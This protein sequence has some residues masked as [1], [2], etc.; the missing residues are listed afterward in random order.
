MVK[1][2]GYITEVDVM[3]GLG[4]GGR[5]NIEWDM[6]CSRLLKVVALKQV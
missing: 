6:W 2:K 1:M 4:C 5:E 3:A